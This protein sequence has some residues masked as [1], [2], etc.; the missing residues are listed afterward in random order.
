M[1][2]DTT[3]G[4]WSGS[5]WKCVHKKQR[6][7]CIVC[8]GSQICEHKKQRALCTTCSDCPHTGVSYGN[9]WE[10]LPD[11]IAARRLS[12]TCH[13]VRLGDSRR[14]NRVCAQC[15]DDKRQRIEHRVRDVL[16]A[17][18]LT[19]SPYCMEEH[20]FIADTEIGQHLEP[21]CRTR[22]G[23]CWRR[24]TIYHESGANEGQVRF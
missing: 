11:D 17:E 1:R 5:Y 20:A 15:D 4:Y 22:P 6:A 10:C 16:V 18:G 7:S 2:K 23:Y 14:H 3:L 21:G 13:R 9:C 8:E 24:P 19:D 12:N